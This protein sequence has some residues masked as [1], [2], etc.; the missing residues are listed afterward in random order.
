MKLE[1]SKFDIE[2]FNRSEDWSG[3]CVF[4][5]ENG[6]FIEGLIRCRNG[7]ISYTFVDVINDN[8]VFLDYVPKYYM[9]KD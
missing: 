6:T 1:F 4:I 9:F 2:S 7:E 3:N 5:L 8:M